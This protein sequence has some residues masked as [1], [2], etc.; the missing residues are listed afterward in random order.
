M[1]KLL[2]F[3]VFNLFLIA[4]LCA[5]KT[6]V[7]DSLLAN[8]YQIAKVLVK[9]KNS[10]KY[11]DKNVYERVFGSLIW[12]ANLQDEEL[13]TQKDSLQNILNKSYPTLLNTFEQWRRVFFYYDRIF[14]EEKIRVLTLI[15]KIGDIET[16]KFLDTAVRDFHKFDSLR[17][18]DS[19]K[20]ISWRSGYGIKTSELDYKNF[21]LRN[22]TDSVRADSLKEIQTLQLEADR[23]KWGTDSLDIE[24]KKYIRIRD[25][26][27]Q[28]VYRRIKND[29]NVF[30]LL[31]ELSNFSKNSIYV[32]P[33]LV[34]QSLESFISSNITVINQKAADEQAKQSL[35][36]QMP[37]QAQMIDAL[38]IYLAKRVKQESILW[39]FEMVTKNA[40]KF[41]L[42]QTFFPNTIGL[43]QSK[44]IY[45]TPNMGTQWQYALSKDFVMLP[46]N[47]LN[48]KWLEERIPDDKRDVLEFLKAIP[49][50]ASLV[51]QRYNYQDI[52]RNM[53]LQLENN[54]GRQ[55]ANKITVKDVFTLLYAINNEMYTYTSSVKKDSAKIRMLRYEDLRNLNKE[56]LEVMLSLMDMKYNS[57]FTKMLNMGIFSKFQIAS[58]KAEQIRKWIGRIQL[59]IEQLDKIRNEFIKEQQLFEAGGRK[60][61]AYTTYNVWVFLTELFKL[62]IP[63]EADGWL[64]DKIKKAAV[65][66][67]YVGQAQEIYNLISTKNFSGAVNTTIELIDSLFYGESEG[68]FTKPLTQINSLVKNKY[69]KHT[70][71]VSALKQITQNDMLKRENANLKNW[72]ITFSQN[73]DSI[74]FANS[75][76]LA[77][78]LY[79]RNVGLLTQRLDEIDSLI[80]QKSGQSTDTIWKDFM[81]YS[82]TLKK[83]LEYIKDFG[84]TFD[85]DLKSIS[86]KKDSKFAAMFFEENRHALTIIRKMSAFLNDAALAKDSKQ[87][88]KVLESYAMPPASYKKKRNTWWSIDL[89]AFVG[90]F[91]G[92]EMVRNAP[93]IPGSNAHGLVYGLSA[94][95]G[96]S[97]SK[98]FGRKA[99]GS[100]L[101]SDYIK[102]PDKLKITKWGMYVRSQHTLTLTVSIIDPGAVVSYRFNN[103]K[104]SILPQDVKWTQ[105]ISPGLHLGYGFPNTPLVLQVGFQYTPQLRKIKE[106]IVQRQYNAT[107]VYVG[108]MFDIPLFNLWSRQRIVK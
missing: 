19:L 5:Q 60:D 48:S 79:G 36:F 31:E 11:Q 42:L 51:T 45:E 16:K 8:A 12:Y 55:D 21:R 86:F 41:E 96:L 62:I 20:I 30:V 40:S 43:L 70:Y 67:K 83:G 61:I 13:I 63:E 75:S 84:I 69:N 58:D 98:T 103:T 27:R 71:L 7:N 33:E 76:K 80:K 37:S 87:L 6:D 94:P 90:P 46:Q 81:A 64:N 22:V 9:M 4:N 29:N 72:G 10:G 18:A 107:R 52:V 50:V 25:S 101:T 38:A 73:F 28:I 17:H 26:I 23:L 105:I 56:E 14:T 47:L 92:K 82:K 85:K 34:A 3:T 88:A 66:V 104:D 59:G 78:M 54:S 74:V 100:S 91:I 99:G 97:V 35:S 106:P 108:I 65:A 89:N 93:V 102:N 44:E 24:M 95:I 1:R 77:K 2:L 15:G 53:Y 39:F 68:F 57:I 32:A 49:R